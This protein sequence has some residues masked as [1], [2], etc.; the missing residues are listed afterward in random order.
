[1]F[2]IFIFSGINCKDDPQDASNLLPITDQKSIIVIYSCGS[3]VGSG[4]LPNDYLGDFTKDIFKMIGFSDF[5]ALR[6]SGVMGKER[7]TKLSNSLLEAQIIAKLINS[8]VA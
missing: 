6:I 7:E 4:A 2:Y 8:R 1:M 5:H 3:E